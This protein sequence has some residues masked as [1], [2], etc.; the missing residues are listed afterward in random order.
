M[1]IRP[2][3]LTPID[4]PEVLDFVRRRA[5]DDSVVRVHIRWPP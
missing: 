3:T 5:R 1:I 4:T 2:D